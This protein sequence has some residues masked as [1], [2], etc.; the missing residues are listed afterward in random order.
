MLA[1]WIGISYKYW[2]IRVKLDQS[3]PEQKKDTGGKTAPDVHW[4]PLQGE[5]FPQWEHLDDD[6]L[7]ENDRISMM[8]S[9]NIFGK[10]SNI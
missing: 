4:K 5:S 2:K 10:Q 1:S 3:P 8:K 7:A 6:K 9:Q